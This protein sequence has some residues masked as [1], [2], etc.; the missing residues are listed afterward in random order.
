MFSMLLF[1]EMSYARPIIFVSVIAFA[2]LGISLARIVRKEIEQKE[3]LLD[4][5]GRLEKANAR[6]KEM[7][8]L[9]S[10]FVSIASHQLRSPLTA[11]RGYAS[12]LRDGT[13]GKFPAKAEEPLERIESSAKSMSLAIEDYLNVSRI[14]AG[15]MKYTMSDFNLYDEVNRVVDDL[16]PDA[17]KHGLVLLF[18]SD[19]ESHGIVNADIGK[20]QQILHNLINNAIKYTPKGT[21]VVYLREQKRPKRIFVDITDTGI[22]MSEHTLHTIFQK[23]ERADNANTVNVQ[24]TGLGLYVAKRMAEAM[25]GTVSAH[26]EGEGKGS[27]FTLELPLAM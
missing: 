25:G 27:R 13:Y 14:E 20:V 1:R 3:A 5:T 8:K 17:L 9:K 15:N 4:L 18:R 7:D 12:L 16:R 22:G 24:G 11:I 26:S 19:L 2:V 21:I 6:L 23:F 10:E